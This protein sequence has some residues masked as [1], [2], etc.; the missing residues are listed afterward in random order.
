M[1]N[2]I[3]SSSFLLLSSLMVSGVLELMNNVRKLTMGIVL[4]MTG[5]LSNQKKEG[6][7][8]PAFGISSQ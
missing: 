8:L 1:K 2:K 7:P 5:L 3:I 6:F 4:E